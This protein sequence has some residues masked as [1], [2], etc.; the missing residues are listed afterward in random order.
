MVITAVFHQILTRVHG[1]ACECRWGDAEGLVIVADGVGGFD[2]CGLGLKYAVARA[3][4]P[5]EV[6]VWPW[7]H[8]RWRWHADLSDVPNLREQAA[9]IAQE[10]RTFRDRVPGAPVFLLGKSGGSGVVVAALEQLEGDAV[11][12]AILLAPAL[13]PRC[14]LSRALRAVRRQLVAFWSPLDL[15]VLG[16]GTSLF[17][18]IDR[19]WG[20]A[21]GLVKFREPADLDRPGRAQYAKLVQVRW[22][23]AMAR[24]GYLGGHVGVDMPW[25]LQEYVLPLLQVPPNAQGPNAGDVPPD[26][27][28]E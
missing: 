20:P 15:I 14:D 11:E 28:V 6:R 8:G 1:R 13:S 7:G 25:F 19:V 9:R 21:A 5:Y 2:L 26:R 3:R 10:V 17:G 24:G 4:R 27:P 23:P 12:V 18:T 22:T 16:I